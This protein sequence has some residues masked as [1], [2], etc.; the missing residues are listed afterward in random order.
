MISAVL[1]SG[2]KDSIMAC[3]EAI[4]NGHEVAYLL[5]MKS[6]NDE[7]YMFHVPNIH[8]TDLIS[9]AINIPIIKAKTKGIKEEELNDLKYNIQ[10][11]KERG[12]E[13]IYTG[14]L[15][16]VYQKSRID[17]ICKELGLK[18]ISPLWHVN[19]EEYMRRIVD[20]GFEIIIT[21]VFAYGLDKSWL[22]KKIDDKAIDELIAINNKYEINIA[23]EGGEA[24]TLAID[25]PI[26]E[27]K[28]EIQEV[29]I[30]WDIDNG[31]YNV[32]KASLIE[33]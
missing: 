24:E 9:E 19:E 4:Q 18:S 32:K 28:I 27:K 26:F 2:G 5:S 3:Y 8:L 33:K 25:G 30:L 10:L 21:G 22:G 14:A 12:V 29:E 6:E 20:L 7:S 17:K 16:S 15:F 13:A 23:F 31:I 11:L 1:F